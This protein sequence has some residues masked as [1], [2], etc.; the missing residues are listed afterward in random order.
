MSDNVENVVTDLK[1][2]VIIL[3]IKLEEYLKSIEDSKSDLKTFDKDKQAKIDKLIVVCEDLKETINLMKQEDA[4]QQT[5][6]NFLTKAFWLVASSVTGLVFY[7]FKS[8]LN[9]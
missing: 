7:V 1:E 5:T 4:R 8:S 2:K 3:T 6:L 9:K